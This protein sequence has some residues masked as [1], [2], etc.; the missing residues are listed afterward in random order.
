MKGFKMNDNIIDNQILKGERAVFKHNNVKISNCT[1]CDGE[2]PVKECNDIDIFDSKFEWRY[3]IWYS[4]NINVEN[5]FFN[6]DT[7]AGIWY[8]DNVSI[9]NSTFASPKNIRRSSNILLDNVTF[10]NNGENADETIWFCND[11]TVKNSTIRSHYFAM[12]TNNITVDNLTLFGKYSFDGG[13][14]ITVT[15]STLI[16]KDAFWNSENITVKNSKI[17][18]E[19]IGWNAKNLTFIDCEI[20]SLQGLCY[21]ENLKLVNCTMKNTSLA[22]EYSSVDAEIIGEIES[23]INPSSGKIVADSI[24]EI[25][26]DSEHIDP[27]KTVIIQRSKNLACSTN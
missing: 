3:P 12:N 16:T 8:C 11:V 18:G 17:I 15:N 25:I 27:T 1:F 9:K 10:D 26:L 13:K 2:S 24:G 6:E 22:F 14:N 20:E 4:N 5:C 21:I 7:R 19:Y 23:V